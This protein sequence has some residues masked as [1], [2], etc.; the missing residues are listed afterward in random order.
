[1]QGDRLGN[2]ILDRELGRGG[3]GTVWLAHLSDEVASEGTAHQAAVKI[4][5]LQLV[6]DPNARER[7]QREIDVLK[8]LDHLNVVHLYENGTHHGMHYYV[9]ELVEGTS[10]EEEL[11]Q[12]GR[13]PWEQV[14]DIAQQVCLALK[15]AHD[16]GV[17]HRDL[18]PSNLLRSAPLPGTENDPVAVGR[19]GL[20][21]L[22]DFGIAW[23]FAAP[24]LTAPGAVVG[25][26]EYIA[27]EQA[28]G[29]Q[30]TQKTD[31]YSLGAVL[32]CLLTGKPPFE[33]ERVDLLHKHRYA[34]FDRPM[35]IVPEIPH[36]LDAVVCEMLEKDPAKRPPDA[37]VLFRR[38]NV[39]R[40]KYHRRSTQATQ[41]GFPQQDTAEEQVAGVGPATLMA[42][43]MRKELESQ[44]R[45]GPI[46]RF[47]N[48]PVILIALFVLTV[49]I[50]VWTFWPTGQEGLYQEANQLMA[51]SSPDDWFQAEQGPIRKLEERFPDHPHKAQVEEWRKKIQQ[52][53][54]RKEAFR[55]AKY[56]GPLTEAK[57]FFEKGARLRE[58]GKTEE[59]KQ[60]WTNLIAVFEDVPSEAPWV[61]RAR[62]ALKDPKDHV[63]SEDARWQTI[64]KVIARIQQ[65]EKENKADE[66]DRMRKA[67]LALYENGN[68]ELLKKIRAKL[69]AK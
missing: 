58:Q 61:K 3:M 47:L 41:A 4:L 68:E 16:H 13:L 52:E 33:G 53:R 65:L 54:T 18:K 43:L 20:I 59:A 32:Y 38:L 39:L 63:Q 30:P 5:A 9:M 50:L 44:R 2:W 67:L 24:H 8:K 26:A 69:K 56:S 34:Q 62:D 22:T 23:V 29:K 17:I 48:H 55:D 66:A 40:G 1:M 60:I 35:K 37:G 21:K 42:E 45:G 31:I 25:T 6:T 11:R 12:Q 7:F 64:E 51:S 57:W 49:G 19:Y 28:A 14:L 10:L 27:P 36:D 46:S 15:H